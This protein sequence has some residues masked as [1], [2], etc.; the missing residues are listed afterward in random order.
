MTTEAQRRA[1]RKY[2]KSKGGKQ[3]Y[4]KAFGIYRK[5]EKYKA[6]VKKSNQ[7]LIMKNARKK[8]YK[9]EKGKQWQCDY[10]KTKNGKMINN[11]KNSKRRQMGFIPL[12]NNPFPYDIKI[13]WHHI[14][15]VFVA[16]IPARTHIR[17]CDNNAQNH[18]KKVMRILNQL[19]LLQGLEAI[20]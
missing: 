20:K 14:T 4:D 7:S 15:D 12:L 1:S 17:L 19:N 11:K 16:P 8:Y 10:L 9:S 2:M 18:R 3:A 5:T 6:V 13:H